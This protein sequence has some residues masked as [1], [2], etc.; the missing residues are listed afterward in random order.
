MTRFPDCGCWDRCGCGT[1]IPRGD[2]VCAGCENREL[3]GLEAI[4]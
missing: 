3:E 2:D 1:L 4:A